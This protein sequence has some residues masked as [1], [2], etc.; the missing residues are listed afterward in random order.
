MRARP[1]SNWSATF[2][3]RKLFQHR[4]RAPRACR[5]RAPPRVPSSPAARRAAIR[6]ARRRGGCATRTGAGWPVRYSSKCAADCCCRP[7]GA[8]TAAT[9]PAGPPRARAAMSFRPTTASRSNCPATSGNMA[10]ASGVSDRIDAGAAAESLHGGAQ[11]GPRARLLVERHVAFARVGAALAPRERVGQFLARDRSR[12]QRPLRRAGV[13]RGRG[14]PAGPVSATA[15]ALTRQAERGA[16]T[17]ASRWARTV[18]HR[19]NRDGPDA[20]AAH[21]TDSSRTTRFLQG[22]EQRARA[23]ESTFTPNALC[24]ESSPTGPHRA[25]SAGCRGRGCA[26]CRN[27]GASP[28]SARPTAAGRKSMRGSTVTRMS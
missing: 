18:R 14:A 28:R 26:R 3:R 8:G 20:V 25:A 4:R 12:A 16:I 9:A 13:D 5:R 11:V 10:C 1:C 2:A 19:P 21:A 15:A 17:A 27:R 24:S 23:S 22:F 6:P 7:A